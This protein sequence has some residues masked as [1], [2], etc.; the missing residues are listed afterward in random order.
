[1]E[2][3]GTLPDLRGKKNLPNLSLSLNLKCVHYHD[4]QNVSPFLEKPGSK[5]LN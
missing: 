1:M 4:T 2:I 3:W 5:L